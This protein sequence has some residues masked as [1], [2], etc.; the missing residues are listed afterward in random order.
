M[1]L[2]HLGLF[3]SAFTSATLL[4]GS[5]EVLLLALLLQGQDPLALWLV[6]TTGNVLGSC[7]NWCLGRV[8]LR[9][10]RRVWFPVAP[11]T[12]ARAQLRFRRWGRPLLLL[13]WLPVV[14]DAFTVAAGVMRVRLAPFL[15][16]VTLAKGGR[17]AVL[18]GAAEGIGRSFG[19]A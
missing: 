5:S 8:A 6:A 19:W 1:E 17:Y 3:V 10:R 2:S 9:F 15:L 12:L 4:P 7:V 13:S 14:G 16:L 18:M 11:R